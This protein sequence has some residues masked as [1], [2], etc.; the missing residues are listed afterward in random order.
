MARIYKDIERPE[1]T[2]D[3]ITELK[4][5]EVFVFGSNLEGVHGGGAARMAFRLFGAVMGCGIGLRGQSYAIPTMH[6]G[7]EEIRPFVDEFVTFAAAHPELFFYVTRVGCGIA[8][9]RDREIAPLFIAA[10]NLDNVC[11]PKGW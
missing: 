5:D 11:L 7:V 10:R 4:H 9:F 2:P 8:G 6:G 1:H 3:M